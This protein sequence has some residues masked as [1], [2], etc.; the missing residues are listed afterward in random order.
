MPSS[1]FGSSSE[2]VAGAQGEDVYA[3]FIPGPEARPFGRRRHGASARRTHGAQEAAPQGSPRMSEFPREEL[4]DVADT[5][6]AHPLDML[7]IAA[8]VRQAILAYDQLQDRC[9]R[10]RTEASLQIATLRA[11]LRDVDP[12]FEDFAS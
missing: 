10:D 6:E 11:R 1:M 9:V 5:L 7:C 8:V 12:F 4:H 2:N 3:E